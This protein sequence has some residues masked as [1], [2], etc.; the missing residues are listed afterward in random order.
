MRALATSGNVRTGNDARRIGAAPGTCSCA[1]SGEAPPGARVDSG[2]VGDEERLA[3]D[4]AAYEPDHPAV[5]IRLSNLATVLLDLGESATGSLSS[6]PRGW[7]GQ[8]PGVV[9]ATCV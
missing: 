5:A 6:G 2:A 7:P 1:A 3:L 8:S 9:V 4:E